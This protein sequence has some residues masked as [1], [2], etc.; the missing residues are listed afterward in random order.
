MALIK[1][2]ECNSDVSSKAK[3]CPKCGVK[4]RKSNFNIGNKKNIVVIVLIIILVLLLSMLV[5]KKNNENNYNDLLVETGS[6]IYK[7]GSIAEYNCY[8]IESIWHNAIWDSSNSD[9]NDDIDEYLNKNS[10]SINT[11]KSKKQEVANSMRKIKKVPNSNYNDTYKEIMD[12]YGSFSTLID[13]ASNPSGNYNQYSTKHEETWKKF[14]S[15]YDKIKVLVPELSNLE[16]EGT[17]STSLDE[18]SEDDKLYNKIYNESSKISDSETKDLELIGVDDY[19][20]ISKNN[21]NNFIL[22]TK[23]NCK[24]C[25][26]AKKILENINYS[27]NINIR[28]LNFDLMS[29][30]ERD[31]LISSDNTFD[32]LGFPSLI[33][34]NKGKI[35][36][37]FEGLETK[38]KYI[39]FINKY[40]K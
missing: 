14:S 35:I 8:E 24:Y 37:S 21:T 13:L 40:K 19:F 34:V 28:Y 11:L 4:I 7:Y 27:K 17:T 12:L 5:I 30:E 38:K 26:P 9:F 3:T 15:T 33:V 1:C 36:D 10:D 22:I 32:E 6:T 16:K 31:R 39:S 29:T 18:E 23:E 2:P 25:E 20:E